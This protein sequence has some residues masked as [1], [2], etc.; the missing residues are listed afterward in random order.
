MSS[1]TEDV[2]LEAKRLGIDLS[3]VRENLLVSYDER[4][5]RHEDALVLAMQLKRA[6]ETLRAQSQPP[7]PPSRRS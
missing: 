5:R 4:A 1:Q 2:I 6:G 3:L 7:P